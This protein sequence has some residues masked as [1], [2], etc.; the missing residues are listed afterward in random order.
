MKKQ[1]VFVIAI[2]A[3]SASA[4]LLR[5]H[6]GQIQEEQEDGT[7]KCADAKIR[8]I[9]NR[10]PDTAELSWGTDTIWMAPES[11][12]FDIKYAIAL[13]VYEPN[14]WEIPDS[15]IRSLCESGRVCEVMGH[16]WEMYEGDVGCI[17][18]DGWYFNTESPT[19]EKCRLCGAIRTK[20]ETWEI[21]FEE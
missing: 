5:L 12:D 2:V 20:K 19:Q 10:D 4:G 18:H 13:D 9:V 21:E 16:Q 14:L 8:E 11:E 15:F 17:I 3:V 6:D 7:W 1:I